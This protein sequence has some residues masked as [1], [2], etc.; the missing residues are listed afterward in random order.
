MWQASGNQ[1]SMFLIYNIIDAQIIE[2]TLCRKC[3]DQMQ[4]QVSQ[5]CSFPMTPELWQLLP[6]GKT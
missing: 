5:R 1:N 6:K 2:E 3:K 4:R